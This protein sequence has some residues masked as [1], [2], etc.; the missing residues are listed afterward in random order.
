MPWMDVAAFLSGESDSLLPLL[1]NSV[2]SASHQAK[3]RPDPEFEH[4][5]TIATRIF[6]GVD[7][8][9]VTPQIPAGVLAIA[10][11]KLLSLADA[12]EQVNALP[13]GNA[14][15][16]ALYSHHLWYCDLNSKQPQRH[17]YHH[18]SPNVV[19]K[20]NRLNA[21]ERTMLLYNA[22]LASALASF[23]YQVRGRSL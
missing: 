6:S 10:R 13:G 17:S 22:P 5:Q 15:G 21:N 20:G 16:V 23:L 4:V 19:A 3:P 8:A 7:R 11:T 12:N 2:N 1:L 9:Y 18:L 14:V